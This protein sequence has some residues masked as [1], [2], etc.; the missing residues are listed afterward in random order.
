MARTIISIIIGVVFIISGIGKIGNVVE[1]SNLIAKYGLGWLSITAPLIVLI[2]IALGVS[3]LLYIKPKIMAFCSFVLLT[4][5]TAAFTYGHFKYGITDCGCFGAVTVGQNNVTLTYLRNILLIGL[6]LFVWLSAQNDNKTTSEWKKIFLIGIMLPMI[7][8]AG[9]TSRFSSSM[10]KQEPHIYLN[11]HIKE[12]ML[13]EYL[14]TSPDSTYLVMWFS[15]T[16]PHCLNSI[17][18]FKQHKDNGFVDN[19]VAFALIGID[20]VENEENRN[21]FI[22]EFGKDIVTAEFTNDYAIQSFIR[23]FPTFFYIKNDSIKTV[24]E[25]KLSIFIN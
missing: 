3:L 4:A 17:D 23:R 14:Q 7:Y 8:V 24:I 19:I 16:C 1:F 22:E 12:T 15:Y 13:S 20:P 11:K 25:S 18:N 6:S 9:Y 5:F 21:I 2:E 10:S